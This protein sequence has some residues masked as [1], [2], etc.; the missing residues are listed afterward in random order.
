MR[1]RKE[2]G[3]TLVE[4]M[5]A[6][7]IAGI[8]M[9]AA[10]SLS[11][12]MMDG[13]REHRRAVEVERSARASMQIIG[14]AVRGASIAV[15]SGELED[16]VAC[17]G[18]GPL[19]VEN[20]SDAPDRL[21]VIHGIGGSPVT[22]VRDQSFD[23]GD[24]RLYPDDVSGFRAGDQVIVSDTETGKIV[25]V[26]RVH[27]DHLQVEYDSC[28]SSWP[29]GGYGHGSLVV[30]AQVSGFFID[31]TGDIPVLLMSS[32]GLSGDG[33]EAEPVALGIE[34]L[35]IAVGVDHAD[36]GRIDE[37]HYSDPGDP[38][39]PEP[40]ST[41][42]RALRI[43]IS[44]RSAEEASDDPISTRQGAEDRPGA[45]EADEF[46]RRASTGIVELRNMEGSP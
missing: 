7:A 10:F 37:W 26:E 17:S 23:V 29:G 14:H 25:R 27:D 45:D 46:R 4:L 31:D 28:F 5:I 39:P 36:D 32:Q 12:S 44:A 21:Q 43:S 38:A 11:F 30:R 2:R 13:L 35:Q 3:L 19:Y 8:A 42:W 20:R 6:V 34:D 41:P 18:R 33:S 15:P 1:P 9:A 16:L 24:A 40:T 22:E